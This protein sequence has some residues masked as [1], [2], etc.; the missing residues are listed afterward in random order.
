MARE[1]LNPDM[2]QEVVDKKQI[3]EEKKKLKEETKQQKKEAKQKAKEL[4][5]QEA[6][7]DDDESRPVSTVLITLIIVLIWLGIL[8][9]LIKLD[10][11]GFGS[12][13]LRPLMEDI[14]VVSMILPEEKMTGAGTEDEEDYYG[15]SSL[16]EAVDQIKMLEEQLAQAQ[17]AGTTY[18]EDIESLKAEIERLKTFEDNQVEFERIKNEFYEEVIYAENGPGAEEYKKYYESMDPT[19][20]EYLYKQV[21]VQLEESKEVTDYANAYSEMKPKEAATIFEA[22][23]DNLDLAARILGVMDTQNRGKI[24]GAMDPE[25]ASKITKIMEPDS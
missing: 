25:V 19:T 10:V 13:V 21:V 1:N 11:G 24:L 8:A 14:P 12:D 9:L 23:T 3:R 6:Q 2:D 4:A 17:T 16:K 22:M 5:S 18:T 15:Y 7:L 20:A